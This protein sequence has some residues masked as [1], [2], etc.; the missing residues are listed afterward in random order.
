[1]AAR[2]CRRGRAA[3]PR[4]QAAALD[5][6]A[7]A[8]VDAA[9]AEL[10]EPEPGTNRRRIVPALW[11]DPATV[12]SGIRGDL[13]ELAGSQDDAVLG[14]KL[15]WNFLENLGDSVKRLSLENADLKGA[16]QS[17]ARGGTTPD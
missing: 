6:H 2:G 13:S 1:M 4:A 17:A 5:G 10:T 15:L 3:L 12:E 8:A 14:N 16:A 11:P 7:V 9:A